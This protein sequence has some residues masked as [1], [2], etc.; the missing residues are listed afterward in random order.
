MDFARL[1]R[2]LYTAVV[3]FATMIGLMIGSTVLGFPLALA[4]VAVLTY[5]VYTFK[6]V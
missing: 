3:I 4:A 5:A 6:L 2:S 1:R